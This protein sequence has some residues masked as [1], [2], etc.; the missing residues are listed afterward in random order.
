MNESGFACGPQI[1]RKKKGAPFQMRILFVDIDTLRPDHMGC[2]GYCRDTTPNM[3]RVCAEG[4]RFDSY[5]CS[6]APCLPSRAALVSGMFGIRNGAVGHGG[7]AGDRRLTGKER[8]FT[9]VVDEN[10]FHNIFRRA[11][12]HTVSVSTFAERHSSWW[13][14][15]G[16]HECYNVGGRGGESGEKVLPVALDW[17]RRNKDRDNWFLHVHFWDP[18]TPYRAPAEFG[19]PFADQPLNTWIDEETFALHKKHTGPHCINE[20]GMYVDTPNPQF[21]RMPGSASDMAGL[22]KVLDGYDCGIRYT[23]YL[24]GQI[25]DLLREQGIYEDTA[26]IITSDHGENMGELG[27]YSEHATA[28][29]PTCHIPCIIKWPGGAKGTAEHTFH[30]NLDILPTM[31]DLLNVPHCDNWD[32]LSYAKAVTDG[33]DTGRDSLVLS[34]MAHVCQRSARFGDW[35]YIRTYHDG[36]HLFDRE[37]LFN[38]KDDPHEQHDVK[39]QH[40]ELCEK[41]AKIILDWHDQQM[42]KSHSQIDPMWTVLR[43]G[44]PYHTRGHLDDYLKRLDATGRK[45]GADA[46]RKK[47]HHE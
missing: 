24:V 1:D 15:A 28:D 37:M 4:V 41:G 46:L 36:Y 30:Y 27:I 7:T 16:F 42:L 22:R 45:E 25:F 20:L 11:G 6:D 38:V 9:D 21:P 39:G 12:M 33:V 31:A 40:P 26:V 29:Y 18:H 44:G 13:F 17:L 32:G 19:N 43:E 10:N 23:D 35:L 2:Y 5:Y 14:N 3:D 47:Y 34:Q 8:D